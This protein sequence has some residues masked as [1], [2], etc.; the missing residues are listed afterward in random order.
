MY[1]KYLC[2]A[3]EAKYKPETSEEL[4]ELLKDESIH[5][6]DIDVSDIEDLNYVFDGSNRKD[7]SGI[8][9][10]DVSK[11][12]EMKGTFR[13]CKYFNHNINNWNVISL[14]QAEDM[15][16]GCESFN[17]PLNNWKFRY[18]DNTSYMFE[19]CVKFNQDLDNW[20]MSTVS[21]ANGMFKGCSS[22]NG[23]ID[24]WDLRGCVEAYEMF[25]GC[26]SL[27]RDLYNMDIG[28]LNVFEM[29]LNTS[30][31]KRKPRNWR[32]D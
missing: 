30:I 17:Q 16:A 26:K 11:I 23:N 25:E 20:N 5:L 12:S 7:F 2:E 1:S 3:E 6:G 24:D 10:W 22:F 8:E 19:G 9:K 28:T 15:F 32:K 18:L 14:E 13:D 21:K 31:L 27:T 4:I 29:G